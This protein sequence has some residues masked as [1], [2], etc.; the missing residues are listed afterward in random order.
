MTTPRKRWPAGAEQHRQD[1]L[2]SIADARALVREIR[3]N[4]RTNPALAEL[5]LADAATLLADA[6]RW[7]ETAKQVG[8]E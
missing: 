4:L 1:A 2:A 8:T 5:M 7:L 3:K 6:Q